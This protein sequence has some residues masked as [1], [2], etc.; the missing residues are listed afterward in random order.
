MDFFYVSDIK[1]NIYFNLDNYEMRFLLMINYS[2][3][4]KH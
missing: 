3:Y 2:F 1:M 4:L